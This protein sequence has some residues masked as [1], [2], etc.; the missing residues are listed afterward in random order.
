MEKIGKLPQGAL[1]C[2]MEVD[3]LYPNTPHGKGL[4]SLREFL[5]TRDN[6]QMLIDTLAELTATVLK[7]NI[8]V[9]NE[10][11]SNRNVEP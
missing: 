11:N 6:K 3:G 5:E 1:L 10:K 7:N 9:F 4:I 2:T 8:L